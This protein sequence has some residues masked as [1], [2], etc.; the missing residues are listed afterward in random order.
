MSDNPNPA[1]EPTPEG[2]DPKPEEQTFTQAEVD[3]IVTE[4]LKRER[5]A[6]RTKYADYDQL[7]ERAG[8]ATTLEE[9]VAEIEARAVKA[10]QEALR[11]R[12][13][14]DVPEKLRPLLTGSTDEDLK[15]QRDLILE[16]ESERK[17]SGNHVPREGN[18]PK[19][20]E[21]EMRTFARGLFNQAAN[22]G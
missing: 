3:R 8:T 5:E 2:G 15:A 17:K 21:D 19:A 9:R 11:A 12:Y 20:G 4:R 22:Q 1:P 16:G 7:K 10:E 13:A 18:N 14:A 6:T